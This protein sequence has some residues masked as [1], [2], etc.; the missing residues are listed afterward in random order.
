MLL[1][2]LWLFGGRIGLP[3]WAIDLILIAAI[4]VATVM[5]VRWGR[6]A[7]E[8]FGRSDPK[9]FVLDEFAGQC[10]ALLWMPLAM[11]DPMAAFYLIGGQFFLFRLFDV[12]KPSPAR[13]LERLAYGWGILLDDLAAGAYANIVGQLA[14]RLTPLAAWLPWSD[15]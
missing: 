15:G 6:W 9:P 12:I 14:W 8:H 3:W 11:G 2:P 7:V 13:E 10:V 1:A 4:A 5:S